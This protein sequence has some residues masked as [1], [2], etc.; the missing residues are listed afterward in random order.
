M[1]NTKSAKKRWRK[2]LEQRDRNRSEKSKLRTIIRKA[3]EIAGAN[4]LDEA[5]ATVRT[6]ARLLDKAAAKGIIHTNKASRLKSRL[7]HMIVAAKATQ[8]K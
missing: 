6:T 3:R 5:Q 2:S 7:S 4:K 8:K 1:P